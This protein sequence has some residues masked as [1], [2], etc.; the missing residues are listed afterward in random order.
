MAVSA[1]GATAVT[2]ESGSDTEQIAGA[3]E[4]Y[5]AI[6]ELGEAL[7][8]AY[9]PPTTEAEAVPP[10][11]A[12]DTVAAAPAG[13]SSV[14]EVRGPQTDEG[15]AAFVQA[16]Y[17][18]LNRGYRTGDVDTTAELSAPDCVACA[19]YLA[20]LATLTTSDA[21]LDVNPFTVQDV[22]AEGAS[23]GI[24]VA[25]MNY[26]VERV[27]ILRPEQ[28]PTVVAAEPAVR[29]RAAVVWTDNGWAMGEIGL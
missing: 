19:D 25:T 16:W 3:A 26:R 17:V 18:A 21:R 22:T 6:P 8:L 24:A 29:I 5:G 4:A 2:Q 1:C 28:P 9:P 20:D 10:S 14:G 27:R 23:S 15:A 7:G 12:P 11:G 13:V